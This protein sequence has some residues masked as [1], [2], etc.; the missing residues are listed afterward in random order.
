MQAGLAAHRSR[1]G[2]ALGGRAA[3]REPVNPFSTVKEH[4]EPAP[5]RPAPP[6]TFNALFMSEI[7][8]VPSMT[9]PSPSIPL[10]MLQAVLHRIFCFYC[11]LERGLF[12]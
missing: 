3:H 11:C 6:P 2:L 7:S 9:C 8:V 1:G 10:E 5:P 4:R 12:Q